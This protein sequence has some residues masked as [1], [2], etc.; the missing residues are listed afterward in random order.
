MRGQR[1]ERCLLFLGIIVCTFFVGKISKF[2]AYDE[3]IYH[4]PLICK[5][6]FYFLEYYDNVYI[7]F[8]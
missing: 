3:H 6:T 5:P 4:L 2:L 8:T 1:S 7:L